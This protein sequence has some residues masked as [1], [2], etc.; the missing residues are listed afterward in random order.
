MT[1]SHYFSILGRISVAAFGAIMLCCATLNAAQAQAIQDP[2]RPADV[3]AA[4]SA[5]VALL[6]VGPQLQSIRIAPHGSSAI[7]SGQRVVV[8][9]HFGDAVVTS[10]AENQLVLKRDSGTQIL[11][12]FPAVSR[13]SVRT[14]GSSHPH[15]R[16]SLR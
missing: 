4:S 8:G 6:N 16:G 7:I 15:R 3:T 14:S 5:G 9:S 2:T 1:T 12:L 13:R 10:I 11:T